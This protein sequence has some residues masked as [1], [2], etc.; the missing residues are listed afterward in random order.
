MYK[1]YMLKASVYVCCM[2][3]L[4]GFRAVLAQDD[5]G[6]GPLLDEIIVTAEKRAESIDRLALAVSAYSPEMLDKWG[7]SDATR[8]QQLQPSLSIGKSGANTYTSIRGIGTELG[9]IG[10]EPGVVWSSDGITHLRSIGAAGLF[11][12][13]ERVEVLRGPQGTISGR[14]ATGGAINVISKRPGE[15][16][17]V[18]IKATAGNYDRIATEGYLNGPIADGK[19][20]ARVAFYTDRATGWLDNVF[21]T[22]DIENTDITF[23][24]TSFSMDVSDNVE[25]LLIM[26]ALRDH[27]TEGYS[28]V[29]IGRARPDSQTIA[30]FV[31]LPGADLD[32]LT[33]NADQQTVGEKDQYGVTLILNW[34]ISP[35]SAI[36]ST[37]GY[38]SV[39][40]HATTD[41]DGTELSVC[42]FPSTPAFPHGI[43]WDVEQ[44][45]QEVTFTTDFSDRLD[46]LFGGI[47][48]DESA[49]EPVQF[50]AELGGLPPGA[51]LLTAY[52][53]LTSYAAYTQ[54]RY[55]FT[56]A[57]RLSVGL[58]YTNDS[59]DYRTDD[60]IF[61]GASSISDNAS[62]SGTTPRIA[63][64]YS[65]SDDLT[66]YSNISRGFKGGGFNTF[67]PVVNGRAD[68]FNQEEV[69]SYEAGIKGRLF[70]D[71]VRI[72]AAAF[73]MD[74]EDLQQTVTGLSGSFLPTVVNA[75]Q[76]EITGIEL[77]VTVLATD[78]LRLG[79]NGTWLDATY[80]ELFSADNV[81]PELGTPDPTQPGL[82][83]RDLSGN[84][85][86]K[87]PEWKFVISPEYIRPLDNGLTLGLGVNYMWQSEVFWNFFNNP[88]IEQESYGVLNLNGYLESQDGTWRFSAF[89]RNAL[90]ERYFVDGGQTAAGVIPVPAASGKLAPPRTYGVSVS[91]QF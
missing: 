13:V 31:G 39:E 38:S 3:S 5:P 81:Y 33:T 8:L 35:S 79:F 19:V 45:S 9:N 78:H 47:Y 41:C 14:N 20:L 86:S 62:W 55:S 43:D 6:N 69:T 32:E 2:S 71:S 28:R 67:G 52:G 61:G 51:I 54:L 63:L 72:A 57:L 10:A 22:E 7:I 70:D 21:L 15:E 17:G 88:G 18:R 56:D 25:A 49:V 1:K 58:R 11:V 90:D 42:A 80:T 68:Q 75:G 46:F 53:D 34:D 83:V 65:L 23:V 74:Y 27:S 89:A 91:Y 12:D 4:L 59:K 44:F 26:S 64:D 30:E 40:V 85:I 16:V 36:T 24:R 76:A 73:F 82:N 84:M 50:V 48:I 77:E 60:L 29:E 66:F 87:V 37:T